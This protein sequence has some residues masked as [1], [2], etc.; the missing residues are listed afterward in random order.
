MILAMLEVDFVFSLMIWDVTTSSLHS[1]I[2]QD[3]NEKER[4]REQCKEKSDTVIH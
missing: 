1:G 3:V 2:Y 4:E